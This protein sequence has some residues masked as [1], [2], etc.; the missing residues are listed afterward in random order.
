MY[1]KAIEYIIA[2]KKVLILSM[3]ITCF[4]CNPVHSQTILDQ[5][6]NSSTS[7]VSLLTCGPGSDIYTIY[8]HSAIRIWDIKYGYDVVFNYGTFDFKQ[9]NFLLKFVRGKL[10]YYLSASD[11]SAFLRSYKRENRLVVE[12]EF[13]LDSLEK[14]SFI[15]FI[16][17][18][19]KPENR[20]Y[21][22]DFFFDNCSSRIWVALEESVDEE[23]SFKS[24]T[25]DLTFRDMISMYQQ[26]V[27]WTNLGIALIIGSPA[28][29]RTDKV[30][31]MFL[32]DFLQNHIADAQ[33]DGKDILGPDR[34][35]I[36]PTKAVKG[37]NTIFTPTN[38]FLLLILVELWLLLMRFHPKWLQ[39]FDKVWFFLIG[40]MGIILLCMWIG[41][42]HQACYKNYHLLWAS[43]LYLTILVGDLRSHNKQPVYYILLLLSTIGLTGVIGWLPQ[44]MPWS[45]GLI[46]IVGIL[47]ILKY[48]G[49]R[50]RIANVAT[51]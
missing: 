19:Y 25:P 34:T 11:V 40:L 31:Q 41:T 18:N 10:P 38:L 9:P 4:F 14:Q 36:Q 48:I 3:L 51:I 17:D 5:M 12:N 27:P 24:A 29:V 47:K 46:I 20:A 32:P 6:S 23:I 22:Y 28:D 45:I 43:P 7:R 30:D 2:I 49:R 37:A 26:D 16:A 15:Q 39:W 8:G 21:T 50:H 42:D 1:P 33:V 35:L 44:Y 13:F